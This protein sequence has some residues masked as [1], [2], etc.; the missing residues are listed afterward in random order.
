MFDYFQKSLAEDLDPSQ[1]PHF[2]RPFPTR[3]IDGGQSSQQRVT[4]SKILTE[5]MFSE[6]SQMTDIVARAS[7]PRTA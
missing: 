1:I 6:L 3:A 4:G 7:N 2:K 5:Y